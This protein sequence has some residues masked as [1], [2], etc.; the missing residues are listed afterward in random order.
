MLQVITK[1]ILSVAEDL[2]VQEGLIESKRLVSAISLFVGYKKLRS[3]CFI[4]TQNEEKIFLCV[5]KMSSISPSGEEYSY[6][7]E[8]MKS[9]QSKYGLNFYFYLMHKKFW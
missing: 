8:M 5:L 6:L 9:E 4:S 1:W 3:R 7:Q 2:L